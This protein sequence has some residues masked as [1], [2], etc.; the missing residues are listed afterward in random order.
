MPNHPAHGSGPMPYTQA[1]HLLHPLRKLLLSPKQ[2]VRRLELR[3]DLTV[4][5]LGPGPG[6][7]SIEV[8]RS[9]PE[10]KLIL[11]DVQREMLDMAR[12]R[13]E[14]QGLRN[15]DYVQADALRL[16]LEDASVDVAFSVA[17]LG[18]VS[19]PEAAL[20]ELRRVL[21]PGARI[22]LTEDVIGDPHSLRRPDLMKIAGNVGFSNPERRGR[23]TPT[24]NL[25]V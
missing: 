24:I 13:L 1:G 17:V 22:S 7:F 23:L 18:E 2:L 4:L 14:A 20:R 15:I 10:G 25:T 3:P 16:P 5:E 12:R 8:A 19:D 21:R 9:L 11:V 6:Y